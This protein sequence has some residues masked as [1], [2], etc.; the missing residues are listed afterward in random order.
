MD[1]SDASEDPQSRPEESDQVNSCKTKLIYII[2]PDDECHTQDWNEAKEA[3]WVDE[4][5]K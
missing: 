5:I 4:M 1:S 3:I 2:Y